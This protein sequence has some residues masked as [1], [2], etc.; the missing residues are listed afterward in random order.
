MYEVMIKSGF[1]AAHSLREYGGKCESIHGHNFRVDVYVKASKLDSTG[2]SIDFHIL[3][4][5]TQIILDELDHKNLND[6]PYFVKTN[7]SSENIAAYLFHQL[8]N[9]LNHENVSIHKVDIWESESSC[10]SYYE[11]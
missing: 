6:I 2:L 11:E 10:A 4:K 1:S 3:K 8:K 9:K 5:K 7:P